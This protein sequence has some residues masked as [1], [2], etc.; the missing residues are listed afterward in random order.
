MK[1]AC[2]RSDVYRAILVTDMR[3]VLRLL[4]AGERPTPSEFETLRG[5]ADLVLGVSHFVKLCE[6][7]RE[8]DQEIASA[9]RDTLQTAFYASRVPP[10]IKARAI[11]L[12][13][14]RRN[15]DERALFAA[16][17]EGTG[18][19]TEGVGQLVRLRHLTGAHGLRPI[20]VRIVGYGVDKFLL[21]LRGILRV[22]PDQAISDSLRSVEF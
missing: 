11:P 3:S 10:F 7:V 15:G 9:T 21:H 8:F 20:R 12:D 19:A 22:E 6:M 18:T 5:A 2:V 4:M 13:M 14:M 1:R 17:Y 16:I